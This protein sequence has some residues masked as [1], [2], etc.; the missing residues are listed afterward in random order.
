MAQ[1]IQ[2][3]YTPEFS[4][5]GYFS[6]MNAA[7]TQ[8]SNMLEMIKQFL[9]NQREQMSMPLDLENKELVNKG[10]GFTNRVKNLEA[11]Q[12]DAMNNPDMIQ[13]FANAKNEDSMA[14]IRTGEIENLL[15]PF[16]LQAAPQQGQK[17]V[18]DAE[19]DN[20]LVQLETQIANEK[21]PLK[22]MA[23]TNQRNQLVALR[24]YTP[25]HW[26]EIDKENTAGGWKYDTAIDSANIHAAASRDAAQ[27]GGKAA[28]AQAIKPAT[29]MVVQTQHDLARL[30]QNQMQDE[31]ARRVATQ[32]FKPGTK[33][34]QAA[35][36]TEKTILRNALQSQYQ[37]ALRF[38]DDIRTQSGLQSM[39][40]QNPN[41]TNSAPPGTAQNP[42][43]IN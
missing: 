27:A 15:Q 25:K 37:Q 14:K 8:D 5:G 29:D 40:V 13:N 39:G 30:D 7:N 19:M 42:I 22:Q 2:T 12:A 38:L 24:G 18:G 35:L 17:M 1:Q 6:G 34:Y 11:T 21:D 23:L 28:W 41:P 36:V 16:K 33:E 4:L 10:L 20:K 3:G 26:G 31:I 9:A 43:K 32:G